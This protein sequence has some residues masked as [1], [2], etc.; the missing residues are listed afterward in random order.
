MSTT[1]LPNPNNPPCPCTLPT[2]DVCGGKTVKYGIA[3]SGA[4][5]YRCRACGKTFTPDGKP[6]GRPT[7]DTPHLSARERMAKS[8]AAKQTAVA[9]REHSPEH[10]EREA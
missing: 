3:N 9:I 7:G 4:Q 6:H 2:G 1:P 5:K 10:R 8:R